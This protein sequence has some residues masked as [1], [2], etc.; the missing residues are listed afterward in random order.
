MEPKEI[1]AALGYAN[2]L[3]GRVT[4]NEARLDLW[5]YHLRHMPADAC[6]A[7]ILEH[8][9]RELKPGERE[10][11]P[12]SPADIRRLASKYRPRC[13]DHDEWP[14]D[15]C[16]PCGDEVADGNR[17][18]ELYGRRKWP[19]AQ[20]VERVDVSQIGQTPA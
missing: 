9:G 16:L 18:P 10:I 1:T 5:A 19:D 2:M 20:A 4:V 15:R 11:P 13:A 12:I 3:D 6:R 14:A 7:A 8:Y 17:A